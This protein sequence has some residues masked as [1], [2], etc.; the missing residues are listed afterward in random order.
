MNF[1]GSFRY[2]RL[3]NVIATY[4][5]LKVQDIKITR[6]S[7]EHAHVYI[8]EETNL[9]KF[10]QTLDPTLTDERYTAFYGT[11]WKR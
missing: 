2:G 1:V 11:S 9:K 6:A 10:R 5:D 4:Y 7:E 3:Q 8:S